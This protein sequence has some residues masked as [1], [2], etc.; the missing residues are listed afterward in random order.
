MIDNVKMTPTDISY[1]VICDDCGEVI[2]SINV[3]YKDIFKEYTSE[4]DRLYR[5]NNNTDLCIK[6]RKE[7]EEE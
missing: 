4:V 7:E 6:C 5:E 1:D 3:A 2:Q